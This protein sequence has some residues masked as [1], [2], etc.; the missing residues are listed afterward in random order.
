[1]S[2][3]ADAFDNR[4]ADHNRWWLVVLVLVVLALAGALLLLF[5]RGSALAIPQRV[6]DSVVWRNELP[7]GRYD[8]VPT[9]RQQMIHDLAAHVLPGKSRTE[10]EG[11]LGPTFT[12]EGMR[13]YVFHPE[14]GRLSRTGEGYDCDDFE[15]DMLFDIGKERVF[16][17]DHRGLEFSPDSEYLVIRFDESEVFSSWFIAGSRRWVDVAGPEGARTY[18]SVRGNSG[19]RK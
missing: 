8:D 17:Y 11:L 7:S 6:F 1:M 3:N 12:Y 14:S 10:I 18:S 9:A 5:L 4:F 15:W 16:V 19:N 2:T 13:S